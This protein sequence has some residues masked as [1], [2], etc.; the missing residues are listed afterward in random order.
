[1]VAMVTD[2]YTRFS[3]VIYSIFVNSPTQNKIICNLKVN[4]WSHAIHEHIYR[5]V[6]KKKY[7][8]PTIPIPSQDGALW[9]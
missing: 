1:M 8:M 9:A 4:T 6:K 2:Q 7:G 3:V 5:M